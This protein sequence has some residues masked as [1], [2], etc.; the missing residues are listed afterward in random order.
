MSENVKHGVQRPV[1]DRA[2]PFCLPDVVRARW[3]HEA[4]AAVGEYGGDGVDSA[5][6]AYCR[7]AVVGHAVECGAVVGRDDVAQV[8]GGFGAAASSAQKHDRACEGCGGE[9][10]YGQ[11]GKKLRVG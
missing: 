5:F 3:A 4:V 1:A 8:D 10:E 6:R 7:G 9:G 2:L 11:S